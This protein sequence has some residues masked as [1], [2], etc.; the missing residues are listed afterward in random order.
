MA[1]NLDFYWLIHSYWLTY[2]SIY[3]SFYLNVLSWYLEFTRWLRGLSSQCG[4]GWRH[5]GNH[6]R[7]WRP[8]LAAEQ[9]TLPKSLGHLRY[10]SI[11]TSLSFLTYPILTYPS[12]MPCS[13]VDLLTCYLKYSMFARQPSRYSALPALPCLSAH[14]MPCNVMSCYVMLYYVVICH[15][16]LYYVTIC[17][18]MLWYDMLC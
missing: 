13:T 12:R 7:T 5:G 2:S 4:S 6:E 17:Y 18:F 8:W 15:V 10:P 11:Y 1:I 16:M 9:T 3:P 14:V